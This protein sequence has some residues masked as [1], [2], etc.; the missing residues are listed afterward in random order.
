MRQGRVALSHFHGVQ[1]LGPQIQRLW[2]GGQGLQVETSEG[3]GGK[4]VVEGRGHRGGSRV[5]RGC[6]GGVLVGGERGARVGGARGGRGRDFR[7]R[8]GRP[9]AT[10][11][12]WSEPFVRVTVWGFLSFVFSF[13]FSFVIIL[14]FLR[15]GGAV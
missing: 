8:G 2:K 1:G 7:G 13:V 3:T 6:T 9:G 5:L 11:G 14:L 4:E 10:V 12:L 15:L